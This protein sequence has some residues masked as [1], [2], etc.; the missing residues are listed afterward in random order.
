MDGHITPYHYRQPLLPIEP[1]I[2]VFP[3]RVRLLDQGELPRARP[4]FE[5]LLALQSAP[6]VVIGSS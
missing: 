5:V 6:D 4:M 3:I 2:K 1:L